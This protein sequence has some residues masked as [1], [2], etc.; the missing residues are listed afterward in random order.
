MRIRNHLFQPCGGIHLESLSNINNVVLTKC[1][2]Q[3]EHLKI[4]YDIG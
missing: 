3:K 4:S 2:T 1:K